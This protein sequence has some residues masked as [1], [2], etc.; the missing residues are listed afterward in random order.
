MRQG[1]IDPSIRVIKAAIKWES[2]R[3]VGRISSLQALNRFHS[4]SEELA[5]AVRVYLRKGTRSR[6]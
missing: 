3:T 5:R 4:A 1:E 6:G 2:S